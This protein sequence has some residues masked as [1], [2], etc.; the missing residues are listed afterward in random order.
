M[1]SEIVYDESSYEN[2]SALS[3]GINSSFGWKRSQVQFPEPTAKY[4]IWANVAPSGSDLWFYD[5]P[6]FT[7]RCNVVGT[8]EHSIHIHLLNI[9]I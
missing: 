2:K 8:F 3:R 5:Y 4:N 9:K 7:F 1:C 6:D